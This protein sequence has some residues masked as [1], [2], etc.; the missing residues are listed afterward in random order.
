MF[1]ISFLNYL[2][3]PICY[4]DYAANVSIRVLRCNH[5]YHKDCID[6]WLSQKKM[7][8][9]CMRDVTVPNKS[10]LL[11]PGNTMLQGHPGADVHAHMD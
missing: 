6:S 9:T 10:P 8:P 4:E 11:H 1:F 5:F 3:C 7:C 2:S